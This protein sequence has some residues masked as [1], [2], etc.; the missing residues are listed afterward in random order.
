MFL[1]VGTGVLACL[2]AVII[3]AVFIDVRRTMSEEK[4][5]RLAAA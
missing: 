2:L 4:R 3:V 1:R 5:R